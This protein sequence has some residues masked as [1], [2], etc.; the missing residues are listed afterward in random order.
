MTAGQWVADSPGNRV[1]GYHLSRLYR[2]TCPPDYPDVATYIMAECE[3]A[4]GEQEKL[5]R[6]V[7]AFRGMPFDGEG[8]RINDGLLKSLEVPG[9]G[10]LYSSSGSLLTVDQG[11]ALH[12]AIYAIQPPKRLQLIY[13][14]RTESWGR[15][16]DLFKR[17][18]CFLGIADRHPGLHEA[19]RFAAEFKGR[20][21]VLSYGND[22]WETDSKGEATKRRQKPD[23]H[24]GKIPIP[25]VSVDRT[26]TLDATVDF[27]ESGGLI[28]PDRTTLTGKDRVHY[29]E[30]CFNLG[31]LKWKYEESPQG[32]KTRVY[33]DKIENHHG[34]GLNFARIAAFELGLKPPP[35]NVLP[36]FRP[37]RMGRA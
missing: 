26:S 29:E 21:W 15:V 23:A 9:V 19:R 8:A 18:G 25:W 1:H 28:L 22:E 30:F 7:I 20:V 13:C 11:K 14:E 10:F 37:F 35:P 32:K 4:K 31:N 12:V 3:K 34:M 36:I 16:S 33:L 27:V 5:K 6:F 17:Y 24:E 2:L